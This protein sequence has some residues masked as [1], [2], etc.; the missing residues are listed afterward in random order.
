V[1][2]VEAAP[3]VRADAGHEALHEH[4]VD[5]RLVPRQPLDAGHPA[6]GPGH[7]PDHPDA[8]AALGPGPVDRRPPQRHGELGIEHAAGQV[9]GLG[10]GGP[11]QAL[12][13]GG[14]DADAVAF[15][16]GEHRLGLVAAV[17]HA[18]PGVQPGAHEPGDRR[19]PGGVVVDGPAHVVAEGDL[20]QER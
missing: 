18:L 2:R 11:Q 16:P 5:L 19:H 4:G 9:G 13:E 1:Q 15:Q 14:A 12:V 3:V 6:A 17:D 20:V 7:V 10:G 8:G